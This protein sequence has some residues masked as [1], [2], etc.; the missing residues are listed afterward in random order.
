MASTLQDVLGFLDALPAPLVY[1]VL[2]AGAALEN[3]GRSES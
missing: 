3:L 2:G 1:L